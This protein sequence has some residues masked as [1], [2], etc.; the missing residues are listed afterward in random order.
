MNK[1]KL[2]TMKEAVDKYTY[3]G[4]YFAHGGA[5]PV[6]SDCISFF[7]EMVKAG[8]KDI[9]IASNCNTQGTNLL[10]AVGGLKRM[11][12]GF[13]GLGFDYLERCGDFLNVGGFIHCINFTGLTD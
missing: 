9:D 4:M 5:L 11:E 2:I 13:S 3:D 10:A 8:R 6:G 7:R 12:V 1:S